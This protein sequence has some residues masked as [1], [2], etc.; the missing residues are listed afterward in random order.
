MKALKRLALLL[1][2]ILLVSMGLTAN[3]VQISDFQDVPAN[4]WYRDALS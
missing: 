4:A 2:V 1:A 3:A